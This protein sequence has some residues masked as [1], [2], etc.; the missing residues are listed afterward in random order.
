MKNQCGM[1]N[2]KGET[3]PLCLQAE[4]AFPIPH[5]PFPTRRGVTLIELL[6]TMT[7]M[8][9]IAAAI[10]GTA[11]AAIEGA[12]EK[13]TQTLVNKIHGLVMEQLATYETRRVEIN[14]TLLNRINSAYP[15]P[16]QSRQRGMALAELRLLAN[17]ELMKYEMP[18]RWTDVING[19]LLS[20][21]PRATLQANPT[22]LAS[23]PPLSKTYHRH[24]QSL[25]PDSSEGEI[26]NWQGAECL[27]MVVMNATGDGE[28]RTMFSKQEVGDIDGDG[29]PEFHDGWGNPIS[30][31][32]WP[33]GYGPTPLMSGD[34]ENDHEPAD[35]F[36][37]DMPNTANVDPGFGGMVSA[38]IT[39]MRNRNTQG[40][41]RLVPLIYSA[42][43]DGLQD[44]TPKG[45]DFVA[46]LDPYSSKE[47]G[48]DADDVDRL[49]G[50]VNVANDGYRD[51]ITNHNV[52]Y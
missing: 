13:R 42:G 29:A 11:A 50:T 51:N 20:S 45:D 16:S 23:A 22:V 10:L 44:I 14:Q 24:L 35:G 19:P 1:S 43:P 30:W 52:E 39:N 34:F 6:I 28:A 27:Y 7:I 18:D 9:I 48:Q 38:A 25:N 21:N 8:A 32:R 41:Y 2:A 15:D 31:I 12:R 26:Y 46:D 17:R 3:A 40:A 4:R 47:A 5:F 37:R 33:S 36:R 49:P